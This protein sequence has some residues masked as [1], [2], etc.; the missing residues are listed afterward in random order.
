M[1][2]LLK[3]LKDLTVNESQNFTVASEER[4]DREADVGSRNGRIF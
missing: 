3:S 1:T 4:R 2:A